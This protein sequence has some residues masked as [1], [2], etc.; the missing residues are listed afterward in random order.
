MAI[1]FPKDANRVA[2][3]GGVSSADGVT[4][5]LPWVDPSTHRLLVDNASSS[6]TVTSVS[7]VSANGFAGT[8]ATATTTPAI[9]LSTTINSPVLAGNGTALVA[10]T[11]T[12][13]GSTVVLQGSPTLTT[14][15]LGSST[16]TTQTPGTSNTTLATTAFV[17]NAILGQNF[18]EAAKY[19]TTGALPAVIYANGSS[20]V[21]A[22][23]TGVA[24]GAISLDGNTP[25]VG[26]RLLVK[27]QVSTFQNGIYVVT[28]VGTA[29]TVFVLTR[30]SDAD[31]SSDWET[32]DSLFVTSGST[33]STTTWAYT[34]IDSPTIGTDAIT[35]VQTAGQGSFTA[36]NGISITGVSIAIDTSVTVDKTTAQTLTNKTLTSPT[37]TTPALGT[38]ASGVMTNVTGTA[39]GLTSGI[40]NALK[41]ATTTVDV[42]AATAP[43]SGQVLTATSGTAATWQT[44]SA[45]ST[46][47]M[48]VSTMFETSGRFVINGNIANPTF[49]TLGINMASNSGF[50]QVQMKIGNNTNANLFNGS[51]TFSIAIHLSSSAAVT[52]DSFLGIGSV[53]V[54]DAGHTYTDAHAGFKLVGNGTMTLSATQADGSTE[55]AS[56]LTTL[57]QNDVLDLIM[58]INGTSSIDYYYRKNGG[59]L[60]SATNLT[61]NMPTGTN[62]NI[63]QLSDSWKNTGNIQFNS[64]G[65]SY[66]R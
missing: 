10:A 43:T 25:I 52:A 11:T 42:S 56:A 46:P 44:P 54:A 64:P 30:S 47:K 24:F 21:G 14:A 49:N 32:G 39:T 26:D 18:K 12:G 7:V 66:S 19:A 48:L 22:T 60:S 5:V 58:V 59:A 13:T 53:T 9:T 38:P 35:F 40:T 31:Q 1:S 6:G 15:V 20:G 37:L 34:G 61:S 3:L 29:G 50:Q 33:L 57:A 23:L 63:L 65:M 17:A 4:P 16:A 2:V 27:N 36:G 55:N 8:V 28:I 51:P 41:S 62:I 45:A